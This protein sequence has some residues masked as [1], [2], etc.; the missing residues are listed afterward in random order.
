MVVRSK[1][2][3]GA[4][5]RYICEDDA[6]GYGDAADRLVRAVRAAGPRV[7][8]R[9][10]SD[11][12]AGEDPATRPCSRDPHPEDRAPAGTP[13]VAHLV[14]EHYARVQEVVPDG[15][16]VGHTVWE[17]DR[18]PHHWPDLIN[19]ID[20]LIVPTEWNRR[21]FAD[22]GVT[23]PVSVVP[24]VVADREPQAVAP[25]LD[26]PGDTVVF[27]TIG[28]WDERKAPWLAI[29]AF[30]RAFTGRDPVVLVVKT[31]QLVEHPVSG[32]WTPGSPLTLSPALEVAKR[33]AGRNDPPHL[34][35][36][37][38]DWSP[39]EV[40]GLHRRSDCYVSLTH[41]EGWG[42][43]LFDAVA[44]GNPVV[45]TGWGAPVEWL[46]ADAPGLVEHEL[47]SVRHSAP[48]SYAPDQQWAEPD[49]DHAAA[50]LRAVAA[51]PGGAR[52]RASAAAT[53]VRTAFAP[54]VVA[55][56]FLKVMAGVRGH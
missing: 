22:S 37:V 36:A 19:E 9:G 6:T 38:G 7:E 50:L 44:A 32:P 10:W 16:L 54:P 53:H 34:H 24:H 56:S 51:D 47:V 12:M 43:G 41:G 2:R 46:G 39:A 15:P 28:R 17:T 49:V 30:L 35:V 27:S 14:P 20:H 45:T 3:G 29:E 42:L 13:T 48:H 18:L 40:A 11:W 55:A 8:Y 33:L 26:L 1:G 52:E 25:P 4:D 31:G 21:A 23:I 5:L